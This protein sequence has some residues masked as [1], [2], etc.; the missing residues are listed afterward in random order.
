MRTVQ[1]EP[2]GAYDIGL[3]LLGNSIDAA[4]SES[5]LPN[6][7]S[8]GQFL[9]TA[10]S[11][12]TAF[13]VRASVESS[14]AL[15]SVSVSNDGFATVNVNGVYKGT[16]QA[17]EWVASL[18]TGV[19]CVELG[20]GNGPPKDG[21]LATTS[22][23]G[24]PLV[25][26][27][28]VPIAPNSP[29][30]ILLR[31]DYLIHGCANLPVLTPDQTI[32]LPVE[33]YDVD[34]TYGSQPLSATFVLN[35]EADAWA[36]QLAMLR[37]EIVAGFVQSAATDS[38]LLLSSMTSSIGA[39]D[40]QLEFNQRRQNGAWDSI[41]ATQAGTVCSGSTCLRDTVDRWLS[42]GA[43]SVKQ[44]NTIEARLSLSS[45]S[46]LLNQIQ[47]TLDSMQGLA[48]GAWIAS[49][50]VPLS[51]GVRANDDF[52]GQAYVSFNDGLL[53]RLLAQ[54]AA[55]TEYPDASDLPEALATVI[56]CDSLAVQLNTA[57]PAIAT[58][59]GVSCLGQLCRT[60]L[61][62]LWSN[63]EAVARARPNSQLNLNFNGKLRLDSHA[64]VVGC[65]GT[66]RGDIIETDG[67][68]VSFGGTVR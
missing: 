60:S 65:D 63:T 10:S 61:R 33:L 5:V 58:S 42:S 55:A 26:I 29:A 30:A 56:D 50:N 17:S 22:D 8:T 67:S 7:S 66:W 1:V 49:T 25:R 20:T 51:G 52:G 27:P 46:V 54:V 3:A 16:R 43:A 28:N 24:K 13:E 9:I 59:C 19:T 44:G 21:A 48:A 15:L 6:V 14:V 35:A 57:A 36:A 47:L 32:D 31:G 53:L 4:L 23:E 39:A 37:P 34:I 38:E 62:N 2:T 11:V 18:H 45:S 12:P 40:N 68:T 64:V 41:V